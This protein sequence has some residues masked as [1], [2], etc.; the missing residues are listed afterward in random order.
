MKK[1]LLSLL[2][3]LSVVLSARAQRS[4]AVHA[5]L[6]DADTGERLQGGGIEGAA[7]P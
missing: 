7:D 1:I 6:V 3:V 5:T 2:L 4:G